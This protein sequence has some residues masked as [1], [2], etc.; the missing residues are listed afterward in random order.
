MGKKDVK[1]DLRVVTAT[2][3]DLEREVQAGRFRKDLFYR[4][5]VSIK[6]PPL[7]EHAED[8][9]ALAH[10]FLALYESPAFVPFPSRTPHWSGCEAIRGRATCGSC[11]ICWKARRP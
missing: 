9:P 8:V 6:A 5:T 4:F 1:V 10:H 3:R 7:R 11:V 2:N